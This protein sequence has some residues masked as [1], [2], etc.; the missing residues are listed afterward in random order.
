M[1][2]LLDGHTVDAITLVSL[3]MQSIPV[4]LM[5]VS[6]P[7][8]DACLVQ[9]RA[10]ARRQCE[11]FT[12]NVLRSLVLAQFPDST[13]YLS[14]DSDVLLRDKLVVEDMVKALDDDDGLGAVAAHCREQPL[15]VVDD[16]VHTDIGCIMVRR[17][18]L[19]RLSFRAAGGCCCV[20]FCQDLAR[21]P[22]HNHIR[23]L[24]LEARGGKLK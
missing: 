8:M 12:R 5:P 16:A 14:I 15:R 7:M 6:R 9:P 17:Y 24:Q 10:L 22:M 23:Y 11:A 1:M 21:L 13:V 18:V 4:T 20:G 19:E 2:P 3:G